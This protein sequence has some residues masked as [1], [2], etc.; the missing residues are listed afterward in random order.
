MKNNIFKTTEDKLVFINAILNP[1][2]P[3]N[4][5]KQAMVRYR[6]AKK[7]IITYIVDIRNN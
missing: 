6:K 3:N 7:Y 5:L 4:L 2:K 1:A